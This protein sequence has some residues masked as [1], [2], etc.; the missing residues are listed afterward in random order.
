MRPIV[1]ATKYVYEGPSV[2]SGSALVRV[3]LYALWWAVSSHRKRCNLGRGVIGNLQS[4]AEIFLLLEITGCAGV[5]GAP[6]E[7]LLLVG[8]P[9]KKVWK[10]TTTRS[11]DQ[12]ET[13]G[14]SEEKTLCMQY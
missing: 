2:Y 10:C 1:G 11:H 14:Q 12:E 5:S 9:R 4:G 8:R 7:Q 13:F 3:L 6:F